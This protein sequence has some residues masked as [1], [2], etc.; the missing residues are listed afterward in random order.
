MAGEW[1]L[2]AT[3]SG[4]GYSFTSQGFA[5]LHPGLNHDTTLSRS[6]LGATS[7]PGVVH[8][9]QRQGVFVQ[10]PGFALLRSGLHHIAWRIGRDIPDLICDRDNVA[11]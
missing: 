8:H 6:V 1:G 5:L 7:N 2:F 11:S 10:I 4:E 3:F 9:F